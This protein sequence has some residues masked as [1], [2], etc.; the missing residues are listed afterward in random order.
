M[1]ARVLRF[2]PGGKEENVEQ[3]EMCLVGIY[4]K[5]F[6]LHYIT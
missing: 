1:A 6:V 2:V 3:S 5:P 4:A